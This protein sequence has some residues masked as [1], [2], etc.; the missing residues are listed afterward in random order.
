MA[1]DSPVFFVTFTTVTKASKA[2]KLLSPGENMA[3]ILN[4]LNIGKSICIKILL[5]TQNTAI[6][7]PPP[8]KKTE[9]KETQHKQNLKNQQKAKLCEHKI[10]KCIIPSVKKDEDLSKKCIK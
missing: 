4:N 3:K 7:D 8:K 5:K 10:K 6:F 1:S 9:K 2:A